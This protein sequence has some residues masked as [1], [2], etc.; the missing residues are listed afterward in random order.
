[1]SYGF[2]VRDAAGRTQF[3]MDAPGTL[4]ALTAVVPSASYSNSYSLPVLTG[5]QVRVMCLYGTALYE[6]VT[7][8]VTYPSGVPTVSISSTSAYNATHPTYVF[9]FAV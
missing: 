3:K 9:V 8:S 1:M 7:V 4:L 6:T 2:L 5:R